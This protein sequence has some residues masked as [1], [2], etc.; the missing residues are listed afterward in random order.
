[1]IAYHLKGPHPPYSPLS[2]LQ[3]LFCDMMTAGVV[4]QD[5]DL[6]F[7]EIRKYKMHEI[8]ISMKKK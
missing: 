5:N 7:Y 4:V 3:H 1:M 6:V 2:G 8:I